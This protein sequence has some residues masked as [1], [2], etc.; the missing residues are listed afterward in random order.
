MAALLLALTVSAQAH[1]FEEEGL[2]GDRMQVKLEPKYSGANLIG[3]EV[4]ELW[5]DENLGHAFLAK[6]SYYRFDTR[7]VTEDRDWYYANGLQGDA[8]IDV[9]NRYETQ[10]WSVTPEIAN[11]LDR[12][13]KLVANPK[14]SPEDLK[15][16]Y[17]ELSRSAFKVKA[18]PLEREG[19]K[20]T[21]WAPGL[22]KVDQAEF[23]L[24]RSSKFG[25]RFNARFAN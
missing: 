9:E 10:A 4:Y 13:A 3:I 12:A 5:L 21:K 14:A 8:A 25:N 17:R 16:I 6:K 22:Q 15:A 24:T 2:L 7:R 19:Q 23:T 18:G 11:A 20:L 1:V